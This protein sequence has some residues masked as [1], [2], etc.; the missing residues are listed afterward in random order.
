MKAFFDLVFLG[1]I[2]FALYWFVQFQRDPYILCTDHP[3]KAKSDKYYLCWPGDF[4]FKKG[5]LEK[6]LDTPWDKNK[7]DTTFNQKQVEDR[8]KAERMKKFIP[9]DL[10]PIDQNTLPRQE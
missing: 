8:Q 5:I 3:D 7:H 9:P 1:A 2:L 4:E 6:T 10:E